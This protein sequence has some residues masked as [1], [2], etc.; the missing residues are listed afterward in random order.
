MCQSSFLIGENDALPVIKKISVFLEEAL[1]HLRMTT[2]VEVESVFF[3]EQ[4]GIVLDYLLEHFHVLMSEAISP[5]IRQGIKKAEDFCIVAS[6]YPIFLKNIVGKCWEKSVAG[7]YQIAIS[8]NDA[9]GFLCPIGGRCV[10]G[11][12]VDPG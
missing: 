1:E 4:F 11:I 3:R 9:G 6:L 10:V 7:C 8:G 2:K 12:K 5:I